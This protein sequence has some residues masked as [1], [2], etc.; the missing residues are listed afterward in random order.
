MLLV[1]AMEPVILKTVL[2]TDRVML[3]LVDVILCTMLLHLGYTIKD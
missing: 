2:A 1:I 3:L